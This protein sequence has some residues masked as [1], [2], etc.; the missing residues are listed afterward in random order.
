M[1]PVAFPPP[2]IFE[3]SA[4]SA[5]TKAVNAGILRLLEAAPDPWSLTPAE[6]R[7]RRRKGLWVFPTAP[8]TPRAETIEIEGPHGPVPLRIIAPERP[9]GAYLHIHG[10]GW[11]YGG[12]DEQ[13]PR[14]ERIAD[15]CGMAVISVDYRLAPEHPYPQG[16]DDCEAA[17]LWLGREAGTRFGT[18]RLAIGGESAGAHLSVVTL[19]RLRDRHGLTPF[20]AANLTAGCYDLR[21]T[22]SAANWGA[23]RLVLNTRDI[24]SFVENFAGGRAALDD[25]DVSPLFADLAGLPR[26]LFTVG[27]RDPLLDD[28][29]FMAGRW[30]ASGNDAELEVYPGGAHVFIGFPGA[31]AEQCL[32]RIDAFLQAA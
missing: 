1:P 32:S 23:Q 2:G 30:T 6:M 9:R 11:M 18:E 16:P 15:R 29:L 22:P 21:L 13:D 28:T 24:R 3:E 17:A 14:L 10:G 27:T 20:A 26:A 25:P 4:A 5:E 8:R 12:A 19:L 31:L 7:E